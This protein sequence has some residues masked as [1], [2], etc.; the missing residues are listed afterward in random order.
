[1]GGIALIARELGHRV[2]GVD[3]NTYPPMSSLLAEQN[4]LIAQGY[5]SDLPRPR[6]D[7]ILIGNALSRGNP[8]VET[9]LGSGLDY[10][11]GP[12]WLAEH[13]LRKRTVTAVAGTH[14]KTTTSAML[15][16]LLETC[17]HAP[18]FLIGA[19]PGTFST[20]ARCGTGK[21]FVVEADEY[22]SAFFDKRPKFIHYHPQ[23]AV[24]NNLEFDHA[25]IYASVEDII[26][27]FH[28]LVRTIAP[29]GTVIVN[30]A[31]PNLGRVLAKGC[32][33]NLQYF[34][35]RPGARA[36]WTVQPLVSDCSSFV[37]HHHGVVAGEVRW[38]L[39][40]H[41]NMTNALAAIAAADAL[42]L[43]TDKTCAA[44]CTFIA[45]RRRL[46]CLFKRDELCVYD[47][48]AHHPSAIAV[49]LEALRL[50][51]PGQPLVAII[52]PRSNTMKRGD[53]AAQLG[54]S[55][56]AADH[57]II[58]QHPDLSWSPVDLA[59]PGDHTR[60]DVCDSIEDILMLL[61]SEIFPTGSLVLMSNGSFDGLARRLVDRL[62]EAN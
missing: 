9:A 49:T 19:V 5:S 22:D 61:D 48:F 58:R 51:H 38:S 41:H 55:L 36:A 16:H 35:S 42:G 30:Q 47:D 6:P 59:I 1:M 62:N 60:L 29:E 54:T 12:Q 17:G 23:V 50:H 26:I 7:R 13:V 34:D 27:Q 57:V 24:L 21:H 40:G 52:E 53:Q 32:W 11:S 8:A 45:P 14:G 2:T 25:D 43:D 10:E 33:S 44:M 31:D 20:S 4:V 3:A 46:Q 56:A 18:G 37:L 15:A 39:F 28:Y